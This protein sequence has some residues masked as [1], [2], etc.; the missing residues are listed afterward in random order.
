MAVISAPAGT[1]TVI[2]TTAAN[3]L[4]SSTYVLLGT[5]DVSAL[6][7]VDVVFEVENTPG[8]VAGN[9]QAVIFLKF[10][11]DGTNYT[12][13]PE[14]GVVATDEPNLR[15]LGALPLNTN[16]V[17]QRGGFSVMNA[18]GFVPPFM[19]LIEKN[20]SGAGFGATGNSAHFTA[21]TGNSV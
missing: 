19:K 14:S 2:T 21:Y 15:F 1:R 20:D 12:T 13:G 9:K 8:V 11:F 10:S 18:L 3:S 4:A 16:S 7:P 6:D 17:P 5:I